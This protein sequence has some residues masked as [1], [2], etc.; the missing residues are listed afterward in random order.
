MKIFDYFRHLKLSNDQHNALNKLSAFLHSED[1]IFVLQGYAGSGK[2]TLLKGFVDYLNSEGIK[3]QLMAPTGRAAK[4]IHQKTGVSASTIHRGIYTYEDLKELKTGERESDLSYQYQFQLRKNR[5]IF[6]TIFIVDEASMISNNLNEAEFFRFGSGHLLNDLIEFSRINESHSKNKIVFVGDPAQLPPIGMNFSPALDATYLTDTFNTSVAQVEM[7][8]VKR[9]DADNGILAAASNMRRSITSGFFNHLDL[10]TNGRDILNPSFSDFLQVYKDRKDKKIVIS[11]KNKTALEINKTIRKDR[12]GSNLPIQPSDKIIISK[13]NSTLDIM[14]GE[15]GVVADAEKTVVSRTI[16]FFLK[17]NTTE[18]VTLTWRKVSLIIPDENNDAKTVNGYMLENYLYGDNNL[19]LKEQ[20][21]LYIDFKKRYP[22][23]KKGTIEFQEA[24]R[25]D[26]FFNCI[27]LK[28]GYA[29][30]C[31][32]AQG[33]EWED[34]FVFWDRGTKP[35]ENFY[36]IKHDTKGKVNA[37]FYR[38]AYT[39]VTRASEKLFCINPPYFSPFSN[40]TFID[41]NVQQSFDELIGKKEKVEVSLN[42][43]LPHL[44]QFDLAEAAASIQEHFI[45]RWHHLREHN[46]DIVG[47][48]RLNNEI[49]YIFK[50]GDKVATFKYWINGKNQFKS[51]FQNIPKGTNSTEF[52]DEISTLFNS[53]QPVTINRNTAKPILAHLKF[54]DAVEEEKPFLKT[55]FDNISKHL[56]SEEAIVKIEH[57]HFRDRYTI[58]TNGKSSVFDFIYN[59][60]GFFGQVLPLEGKCNAPI[61]LERMKSIIQQLKG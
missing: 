51:N 12:F 22:Q 23:L 44:Q 48:E 19:T 28:Y 2:T 6:N 25:S 39:A 55:L 10:R 47:W 16:R 36:E 61:L 59:K 24:I 49:R 38:W 18:V 29:V 46:I 60:N 35:D 58:E 56:N 27:M 15:F 17:G 42:D 30:T 33:G 41:V 50:K 14:N 4:V 31:H 7:K 32:K 9:Q 43:V 3:S 11:W 8:E 52:F 34:T 54:D 20:R 37:D 53:I 57:L 21:A 5:D 26:K 40:M 13:N 45:D 1:N